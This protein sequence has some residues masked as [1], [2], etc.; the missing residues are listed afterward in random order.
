MK[1]HLPSTMAT[2]PDWLEDTAIRLHD[3]IVS[4]PELVDRIR[5]GV[6]QWTCR[7]QRSRSPVVLSAD[8]EADRLALAAAIHDVCA[9]GYGW[10]R[11]NPWPNRTGYRLIKAMISYGALTSRVAWADDEDKPLTERAVEEV[12]K[13]PPTRDGNTAKPQKT[14]HVKKGGRPRITEAEQKEREALLTA[15]RRAKEA[16]VHEKDFCHDHEC[17]LRR[18]QMYRNW[19]SQRRRRNDLD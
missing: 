9:N 15:W 11:F 3:A 4:R 13:E 8:S 10:Q 5:H 18:L 16:G 6:R 2:P 1:Q 12:L 7:K 14:G 17:D 19:A